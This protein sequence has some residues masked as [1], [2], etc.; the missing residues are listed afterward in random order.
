M[1]TAQDCE[2][3]QTVPGMCRIL[4]PGHKSIRTQE[5]RPRQAHQEGHNVGGRNAAA[6]GRAGI[7]QPPE[8][9]PGEQ[10]GTQASSTGPRVHSNNRCGGHVRHGSHLVAGGRR[11]RGIRLRLRLKAVHGTAE[12]TSP[13][14]SRVPR[15]PLWHGPFQVPSPGPSFPVPS[16]SQ[17]PV[18]AV[19]NP[20]TG[21]GA[22]PGGTAGVPA[23]HGG[24]L[25]R[26]QDAG[27]R[28]VAPL[29]RRRRTANRRRERDERGGH[30]KAGRRR[31]PGNLAVG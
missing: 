3:H 15:P 10:A 9:G 27:G 23:V 16:G 14:P 4:S 11:R 6:G 5:P 13:V 24:V 18:L 8:E 31:G 28:S 2:G 29:L 7:F 22:P 30:G 17:T 1:E 26:R 25:A 20:R 21:A 19:Q 12:E